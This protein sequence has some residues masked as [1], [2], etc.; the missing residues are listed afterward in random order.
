M[1]KTKQSIEKQSFE[2]IHFLNQVFRQDI[3]KVSHLNGKIFYL[4]TVSLSSLGKGS[5]TE[6]KKEKKRRNSHFQKVQIENLMCIINVQKA[7]KH[8]PSQFP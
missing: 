6:Y 7:K 8:A 2:V 1:E 5:Q 3:E 4:T